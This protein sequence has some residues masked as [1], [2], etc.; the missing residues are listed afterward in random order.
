MHC[1][2]SR[3]SVSSCTAQVPLLECTVRPGEALFF[4][5][6][7]WHSTLNIDTAVYI[8]TFL[9]RCSAV[10]YRTVQYR[11]EQ[12]STLQSTSPP[13]SAGTVQYRTVQYS[14]VYTSPSSLAPPPRS[15][16]ARTTS[17]EGFEYQKEMKPKLFDILLTQFEPNKCTY[18]YCLHWL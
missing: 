5:W 6:G 15:S 8:T 7:W 10:Q 2:T 16:R 13:S 18:G 9:S 4:P 1:A 14:T 12:Y 17:R 3:R 11:T